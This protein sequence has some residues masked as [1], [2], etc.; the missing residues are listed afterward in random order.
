M[1]DEGVK[2]DKDKGEAGAAATAEQAS[3]VVDKP[4]AAPSTGAG[5]EKPAS[6][7]P[8]ATVMFKD[9]IIIH[10]DKPLAQYSV[11]RNVAYRAYARDK[12][13]TP[14]IAIVCEKHH[15]PRMAAIPVYTHIIN[16]NLAQLVEH[17]CVYWAPVKQERYVLIYLDVLGKPLHMPGTKKALG[18]KQDDVMNIVVKSMIGVLQD[19]RD[20]DFVH[21]AIRPS[22]MFDAGAV[23]KPKKIILGDC[24]STVAS[25]AQS[26]AFEPIARAM[27]TPAG[28][29]KGTLEDDMYAFGVS[30]AV[31]LRQ[32]DPLQG[33]SPKEIVEQKITHGSYAAV[34]GKDR[35]KGEILELLR[36]L[37]HDEASQRWTIDEILVWMDGRRLSPKQSVTTKKAQRAISL[38]GEKYFLPNLLALDMPAAGAEVKKMIDDES[39]VLWMGRS[40]QDDEALARLEKS[41]SNARQGGMG[42]GYEERLVA[43]VSIALDPS[44]PLRYKGYAIMGEGVGAAMYEAVAMKQNLNPFAEMFNYNLMSNWLAVQLNSKLDV[45]GLHNK[46]ELVRRYL[47]SSRQGEGIERCLY[48]LA[49]DAPCMSEFLKDY[50]VHRSEDLLRAYE[51]LCQK[52]RTPSV[53]ID[54]HVMAFLFQR[55]AKSIEPVAFDLNTSE[56]H[57]VVLGT[58]KCFATIQRRYD[59]EDLPGL[60]KSLAM[61]LPA[62]YKR[63]HDRNVREKL[64]KSVEEFAELGDLQKMAALLDNPDLINK[65]FVAFRKAMNEFGEIERERE[66][67]EKALGD[68]A[69]FGIQTGKEWAVIVSCVLSAIVILG[70]VLMFFQHKSFF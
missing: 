34:T 66:A 58:L 70:S 43:N 39:L 15:L 23:G 60:T 65:D 57:R 55:D 63:Y 11:D 61:M 26:P 22:N 49:P 25:Y 46:F 4:A 21:G 45:V 37:L 8:A 24:L 64:Q 13:K 17:G 69:S 38:M 30:L 31:L 67:L 7:A 42:P 20:K 1:S 50:V 48:L 53:F 51:D 35:F 12:N 68:K 62:V 2:V 9:K 10:P 54:R 40:L 32:N 18:W 59:V 47:R 44:A 41:I 29:G 56:R 14:L 27:A 16:P 36:G 52:K 3:A 28:R 5:T 19:F 6:G 33:M